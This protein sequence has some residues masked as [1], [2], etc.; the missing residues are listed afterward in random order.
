MAKEEGS[1][2]DK[3]IGAVGSGSLMLLALLLI[4]DGIFGNIFSAVEG[5]SKSEAFGIVAAIPALTIAYMIGMMILTGSEL[6]VMW[7]FPKSRDKERKNFALIAAARN[8]ILTKQF[9]DIIR[10]RRV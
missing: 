10:F 7:W 6:F 8:D 2:I 5:Y 4:F 1:A 9:E 3:S